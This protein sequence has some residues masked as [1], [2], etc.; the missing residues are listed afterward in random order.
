[1]LIKKIDVSKSHCNIN[2]LEHVVLTLNL[3]YH[4]RRN[5]QVELI[6]PMNTRSF[7]LMSRKFNFFHKDV[8]MYPTM[9]LHNWGESPVGEWKVRFLN[10]N[11]GNDKGKGNRRSKGFKT[12]EKSFLDAF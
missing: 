4:F 5:L 6:S 11:G 8:L 7:M 2:Y 1:M 10:P 3:T 12:Y 9:S